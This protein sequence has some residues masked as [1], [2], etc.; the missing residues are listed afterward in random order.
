MNRKQIVF[1]AFSLITNLCNTQQASQ[2]FI[3]PIKPHAQE[4]KPY[5]TSSIFNSLENGNQHAPM[6]IIFDPIENEPAAST[7]PSLTFSLAM[8]MSNSSYPIIVSGYLL[9]NLLIRTRIL[10]RKMFIRIIPR[11]KL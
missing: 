4:T 8:G 6:L 10:M 9:K 1:L 2:P 5:Y 3:T 7:T 11:V